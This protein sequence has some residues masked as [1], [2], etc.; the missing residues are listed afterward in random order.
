[1]GTEVVTEQKGARKKAAR[2]SEVRAGRQGA[3]AG[4][5]DR[6]RDQR[7]GRQ[8]EE[9]EAR[10]KW[11]QYSCSNEVYWTDT[12]SAD[13]CTRETQQATCQAYTPGNQVSVR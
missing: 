13:F 1:V 5:E 9:P 8:E 11:L 2:S 12:V 4:P 10:S 7:Q 6:K 3:E